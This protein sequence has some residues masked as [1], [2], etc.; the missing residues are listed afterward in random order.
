MPTPEETRKFRNVETIIFDM[1]G[2]MTSESEYWNSADLTVLELL[3]SGQF[4][5]LKNGTMGTILHKPGVCVELNRFVSESFIALLKNNGINT[6]WDLA[7]FSAALYMIDFVASVKKKRGVR[8]LFEGAFDANAI[9]KLGEMLPYREILVDHIDMA[10][11][12]FLGFRE[13]RLAKRGMGGCD[14]DPE[15]CARIFVDDL[16]AW[17]YEIT[18]LEWPEFQREDEFWNLCRD[19]FQ[20][21]Y[22]GDSL[23][24][25]EGFSKEGSIPKEGMIW[26]ENPIIPAFRIIATMA[27]LKEA[28][29]I[30]GVA[31]GRPYR[32]IM[33]P[34]HKWGLLHFFESRRLGTFREIQEA[35]KYFEERGDP[36]LLHKP[37]PYVYLRSIF[38]DSSID[39]LVGMEL[40]IPEDMGAKILIVGDSLSDLMAARTIGCLSA[41]V[42]TGVMDLET[43]SLMKKYD[44]DFILDDVSCL[45]NLF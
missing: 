19:L 15:E 21:W 2:V 8:E 13:R 28:G 30:L 31:T 41:V 33:V 35:E 23:L 6:N 5:G 7:F 24:E 44:P 37:N 1:D 11:A 3:Y 14:R 20:E 32:E 12:Y 25:N 9:R 40:P 34:L 36:K 39:E 27:M 45:E 4:L 38:P 10:A 22:L 17:R 16:N 29:I 43:A 18:G 42:M 26:Y